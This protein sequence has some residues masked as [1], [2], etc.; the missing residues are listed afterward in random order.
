MWFWQN[1]IPYLSLLCGVF[2][3][4]LGRNKLCALWLCWLWGNHRVQNWVIFFLWIVFIFECTLD[5]IQF[6]LFSVLF[7]LWILTNGYSCITI[8]SASHT[9]PLATTLICFLSLKF[10]PF[11]SVMLMESYNMYVAFWGWIFALSKMH[12]KLHVLVL[13]H[14]FIL[15]SNIALCAYAHVFVWLC[16][17]W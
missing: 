5:K 8:T 7:F 13:V 16:A 11:Q 3:R 9:Q 15:M 1:H 2:I 12:L 17:I 4:S 10:F 6:T 14:N